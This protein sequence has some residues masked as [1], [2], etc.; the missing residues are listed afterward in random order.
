MPASPTPLTPPRPKRR[1]WSD[2]EI[3][4]LTEGTMSDDR[5]RE[6]LHGTDSRG[7][8]PTSYAV[9]RT[10]RRTESLTALL[11]LL[12]PPEARE[13]TPIDQVLRLLEAIAEA[14]LRLEARMVAIESRLTARSMASPQPSAP[15]RT[16]SRS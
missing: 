10:A 7:M 2:T 9:L 15:A 13:Q 14:Q 12:D 4:A 11:T 3:S 1:T 5:I 8:T 16:G 6:T